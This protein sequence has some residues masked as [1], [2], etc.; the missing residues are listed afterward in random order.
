MDLLFQPV[1]ILP[2]TYFFSLPLNLFHIHPAIFRLINSSMYPS[3]RKYQLLMERMAAM[4]QENEIIVYR[5]S[6]VGA[7]T[8]DV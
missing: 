3:R 2:V 4:N 7:T 8:V 6:K 1:I 5:I